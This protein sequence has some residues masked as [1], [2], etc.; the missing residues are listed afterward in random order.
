MLPLPFLP[1]P[2]RL[3]TQALNML[4][5]REDWARE[6]LVRHAGKTVRFAL[7]GSSLGLTI[8]SDGLAEL[9]DPAVV[10]DVTLTVS[11]EK[12]PLPLPRLS[13]GEA[14]DMAEATHISGDAALAQVVA[15]LSKQLRWD[16]E[17][18]LARVVGDIAALRLVG[19]ARKLAGG[20]LQAGQRAAENVSEYLAEESGLLLG[21]P[22]L[23]QWRLDLAELDARAEA[24]ARSAA[25]LQTKLAAAGAKRGA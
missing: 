13:G 21:R 16:P 15:D 11:P 20:T 4:L 3:A 23:A 18:A 9:S 14:P 22:A 2:S 17:D 12:L 10:P 1:T 7:G 19:G 24:L 5:K 6:R 25:A 8:G